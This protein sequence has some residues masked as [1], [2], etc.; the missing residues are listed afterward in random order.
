[1]PKRRGRRNLGREESAPGSKLGRVLIGLQAFASC[2]A[3]H[4]RRRG[5]SERGAA[6]AHPLEPHRRA[7]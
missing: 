6:A 2:E 5:L 3:Q 7:L 1:M 4:R